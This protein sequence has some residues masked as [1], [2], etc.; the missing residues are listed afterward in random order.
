MEQVRQELLSLCERARA[1]SQMLAAL[2]AKEKNMALD[3]LA[4][5]LR[6]GREEILRENAQDLLRGEKNGLS[7]AM[8]DRLQLTEERIE[9]MARGVEKLCALPDPIGV[10][11]GW[12]HENGM[13][14]LRTRVP[15]GVIGIVYEARPNVT[16][17]AAAL[18]FKSGNAVILRGGKEALLSN[19]A[20]CRVFRAALGKLGLPQDAVNLIES[21]DRAYTTALLTLEGHVDAVIP[22]GG[23][24]L[25]R[26][27]REAARVPVIETG[28]GNCH[29]YV[30]A[31]ANLDMAEDI[32]LNAKVSRPSV[33]NAVEHLLV[34]K[35]AAEAFLPRVQKTLG[36]YGVRFRVC[37]RAMP[38]F[39]G[40]EALTAEDLATEFNDLVLTV[41]VVDSLTEAVIHV[42]R[43]GTR[44]SET[45]VTQNFA[46]ADTFQR[47]VDAAC[48]Y[49]NASSRFTDGEEFGFGAEIGISTQKL[50]ARGPMGLKELTTTKYLI[51]GD[52][53]TRG[54][55]PKP[56]EKE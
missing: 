27:V 23:A 24:G 35:E 55:P 16:S 32:L 53:Q 5:A 6:A 17:D 7:R 20:I 50:H 2:S 22:R 10:S 46:D 14:I 28:A 40:A 11:E 9:A 25:I 12:H 21:A 33:C 15:L 26:A 31:D 41:S 34:H 4:A 13:Q 54:T 37:E 38:Y 48:V 18:C 44:H 3:A 19:A 49:V 45:I 42:N 51:R 1:A 52:G 8:L 30:H 56:R 43:Y 47:L 29:L 36:A 39:D